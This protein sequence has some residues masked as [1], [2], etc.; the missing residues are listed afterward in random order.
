MH[1]KTV[2]L[3]L[4]I[5]LFL[6]CV[7][8]APPPP[9]P[10]PLTHEAVAQAFAAQ[11]RRAT[12]A[13]ELLRAA[14]VEG[15]GLGS[16]VL[17]KK[18]IRVTIEGHL[19]AVR[20]R[21]QNWIV[22]VSPTGCRITSYGTSAGEAG[23]VLNVRGFNTAAIH[24]QQLQLP[25]AVAP[26]DALIVT[27][28]ASPGSREA[29]WSVP[30]GSAVDEMM[31]VVFVPFPVQAG[32]LRPPALGDGFLP[33]FLRSMPVPESAIDLAK[34]PSVVDVDALQL[35]PGYGNSKPGFAY[36]E[37]L[38]AD[39]C[40]EAYD[41]WGTALGT[42]HAQ[43]PGYGTNL[44]FCVSQALVMCCSKAPLEQ[45]RALATSL[46]QWG[47]DLAGAWADGR[48]NEANGGHMQ[49]RRA[50]LIFSGH[51]LGV[52]WSDPSA[53]VPMTTQEEHAYYTRE[54]AAWWFG[55]RYGWRPRSDVA[56]FLHR[57]P[58]QWTTGER[59]E[60]FFVQGYLQHGVGAQ[61]GTALAMRLMGLERQMGEAHAGMVEQWMQGPPPAARAELE[62]IGI[63]LPWGSDYSLGGGGGLCSAAWR[64][65]SP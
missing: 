22:Q 56:P 6:S 34:L 20:A 2:G 54:P 24:T 29:Y 47:F 33:R 44:A 63:V 28:T 40:G 27:S 60:R 19:G 13:G 38:F 21:E 35:P 51:L 12:P 26:C 37:R 43:H 5:L 58:S 50:L 31:A 42:P 18:T 32:L 46:V 36:Y 1:T 23:A 3:V 4:L 15:A 53:F 30:G 62:A 7:A 59:G 48:R 41:G 61:I 64:A 14:A 17:E 8:T 55:W 39:F 49:G 9:P 45:K 65:S 10:S 25:R 11:L 57:H 16:Q 52:P